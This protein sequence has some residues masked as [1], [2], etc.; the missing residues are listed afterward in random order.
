[1][2][3]IEISILAS[4]LCLPENL[5]ITSVAP[6]IRNL[7]VQIACQDCIAVCPL[8]Y[9]PSERVHGSYVRT[10]ADVPCGGRRVVLYLTVRKFV[11]G[12]ADGLR[13]IFTERLPALVESYA[14]MTKRLQALLQAI[15]LIAGGET[16]T[17]LAAKVGI[18]TAPPTLLCHLMALPQ[19]DTPKVRILGVDDW[20]WKKGRSSGTILVDLERRKIIDL[21]P[22]RSAAPFAAWLRAH[23][24]VEIISRDRGTDYAAAA[25]EAAPQ[26]IQIAD[27]FHLVRNLA[28]VLELLLARRRC[29]NPSRGT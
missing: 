21:L 13:K 18:Q 14:R 16:G 26:A 24:E 9:S 15:G 25:R 5:I 27:R 6:T 2:G 8:C 22:D 19:P 28:D 17:R 4:C 10:I 20:S 11:C 29:G 23:P 7:E 12:R 1:M 3:S